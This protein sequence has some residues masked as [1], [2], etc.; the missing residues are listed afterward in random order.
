[1]TIQ[2][3]HRAIKLKL[4]KSDSLDYPSFL[5][6][7]IDYWLNQAVITYS[8]TRYSGLNV[9]RESFEQTQKRTDDLRTLVRE[10]SITTTTGTVKPNSHIAQLP[11]DYWFTLGEEVTISYTLN[12]VVTTKRQGI[13]ELSI[14]RYRDYIDNPFGNHILHYYECRPIRLFYDDS[15]ELISDGQYTIPNYYLRYLKAPHRLSYYTYTISNGTVE[16]GVIYRVTTTSGSIVYDGNTYANNTTFVG[17][18]GVPS[19][20]PAGTGI[21]VKM[22]GECDLPEHTH[23][24]I[25]T[26]AISMITENIGDTQRY[27]TSTIEFNKM[28]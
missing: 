8:K 12:S 17:V 16:A 26:L 25:V 3:F 4:D 9:K 22:L 21:V 20:T 23:D 24:E 19:Y 15:V 5:P 6:E 27:Q 1:M 28:E 7:E 2:E 14:D 18:I 10:V 13:T 11:S